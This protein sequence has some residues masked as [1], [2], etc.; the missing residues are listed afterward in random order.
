M[1]AYGAGNFYGIPAPTVSLEPP[2][3]RYHR[4]KHEFERTAQSLW[5]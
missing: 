4:E 5:V 3:A 1:A 2:S